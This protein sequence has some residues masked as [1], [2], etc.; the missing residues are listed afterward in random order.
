MFS[1]HPILNLLVYQEI[2]RVKLFQLGQL[3]LFSVVWVIQI[4]KKLHLSPVYCRILEN[5][6][7]WREG[8]R[9]FL[10]KPRRVLSPLITR[11]H[12]GKCLL[13]PHNAVQIT[14]VHK[15][16]SEQTLLCGSLP[17][18]PLPHSWITFSLLSWLFVTWLGGLTGG[19]G[20]ACDREGPDPC[21]GTWFV[22]LRDRS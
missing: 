16:C 3:N 11:G 2:W 8:G 17:S 18:L 22:F 12:N 15:R 1:S 7:W 19:K 21:P 4:K 10:E 20:P 14:W 6:G 5:V 9:M 13:Q